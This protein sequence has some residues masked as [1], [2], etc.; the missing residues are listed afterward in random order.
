MKV[1]LLARGWD[2]PPWPSLRLLPKPSLRFQGPAGVG[3]LAVLLLTRPAPVWRALGAFAI[4]LA[5]VAELL[6]PPWKRWPTTCTRRS[7]VKDIAA[8]A[9]LV[10]SVTGLLLAVAFL[11]RKGS[12]TSQVGKV[13]VTVVPRPSSL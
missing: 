5:P 2:L 13:K 4:G 6:N 1:S 10:A 9:D 8:G 3:V 7:A 11:F 12:S